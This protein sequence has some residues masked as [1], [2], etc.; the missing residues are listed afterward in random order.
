MEFPT[1]LEQQ[2]AAMTIKSDPQHD[3]AKQ[4]PNEAHPDGDKLSLLLS[5]G[6]EYL[7]RRQRITDL[8]KS[9]KEQRK[10]L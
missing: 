8:W 10:K 1:S 3:V 4:T 5:I 9:C 7:R 6:E 2:M